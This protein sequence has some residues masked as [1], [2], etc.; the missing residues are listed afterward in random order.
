MGNQDLPGTRHSVGMEVT[1][2]LSQT[3]G[4]RFKKEKE[5]QSMIAKTVVSGVTVILAKPRIPMNLNGRAAGKTGIA[6]CTYHV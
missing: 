5:C 4:V 2:K 6:R 1:D 3:F